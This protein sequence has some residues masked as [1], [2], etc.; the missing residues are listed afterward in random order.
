MLRT[1]QSELDATLDQV[2]SQSLRFKELTSEK[3]EKEAELVKLR[4]Q[5][6]KARRSL[7]AFYAEGQSQV[8]DFAGQI[9]EIVQKNDELKN[10]NTRCQ[11]DNKQLRGMVAQLESDNAAILEQKEALMK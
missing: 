11:E 10:E 9:Q 5:Y 1:H 6:A 8:S 3:D 2:Q 7:K 4:E